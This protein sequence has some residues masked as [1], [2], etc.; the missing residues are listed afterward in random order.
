MI[1]LDTIKKL[2]LGAELYI[3]RH[4]SK[5]TEELAAESGKNAENTD[6]DPSTP[7][8]QAIA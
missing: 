1:I 6:G 8:T 5:S 7:P 2:L 4:L 3:D